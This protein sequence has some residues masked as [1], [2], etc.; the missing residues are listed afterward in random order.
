MRTR[1]FVLLAV[2]GALAGCGSASDSAQVTSVAHRYIDALASGNGSE[3]CSLLTGA[4]KQRLAS[5]AAA[6]RL[7]GGHSGEPTCASEV[8]F[9]HKLLG[10]DQIALL[11]KAKLSVPSLSGNAATVRTNAG[12]RTSEVHLAKTAAG[13]LITKQS[14]ATEPAPARAEGLGTGSSTT[15]KPPGEQPAGER[16]TAYVPESFAAY[17][18]QLASGQVREV[19]FNKRIRTVRVTLTDG[20]HVKA[21]YARG[22]F[23]RT[24]DQLTSKHVP[25][26]ILTR[27]EAEQEVNRS[28]EPAS[29]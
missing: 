20:R 12:G 10:A 3:A 23:V 22:E 24:M 16:V 11:K 13:W 19:T 17:E 15:E 27:T 18:A 26:T 1:V 5:A 4:A 14:A 21:K 2:G 8:A 28:E 29:P 25:A 6:L 9:A 7:F